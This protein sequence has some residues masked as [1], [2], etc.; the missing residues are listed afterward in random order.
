MR[1]IHT[2][3]LGVAAVLALAAGVTVAVNEDGSAQPTA[4]V[5][6]GKDA[7]SPPSAP[8]STGK[9]AC[10]HKDTPGKGWVLAI[11]VHQPGKDTYRTSAG[12]IRQAMWETDQTYDA[13][14]RRFGVSRRIRFVQDAACRPLVADLAFV[15]GRNRAEMGAEFG[16]Q[17]V[18]QPALVQK[19]WKA[20]RVKP[21]F[22][23][24]D[25]EITGSCTGGGADA[26]ISNGGVILPLWC[27][28]EAGLTHEFGHTFGLSHCGNGTLK[29]IGNDPMCRNWGTL[30]ECTSD[31]G[32]NYFLDSCRTDA[33]RYFEPKPLTGKPALPR[34]N[35][36]AFSP[37]LITNQ[38]SKPVNFRMRVDKTAECVD[39]EQ[40]AVVLRSCRA[41]P[42]Q[43]WQRRIDREGYTTLR[44]LGSGRCLQMTTT[45]KAQTA[46][47]VTARCAAGKRS[48][49]WL[50]DNGV[51]FVN[52]TGGLGYAKLDTLAGGKGDG[53]LIVRGGGAP[54]VL[55]TAVAKGSHAK[56][57]P[58]KVAIHSAAERACL[59]P[60]GTA[61]KLGSCSARWQILPDARLGGYGLRINGRCLTL[62]AI[63]D[64]D[65]R[66]V[67][68]APCNAGNR[69]QLWV[70]GIRTDG[71]TRVMNPRTQFILWADMTTVYGAGDYPDNHRFFNIY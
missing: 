21:L 16:K 55:D 28:G 6:R 25:N 14:A 32:S 70:F 1:P 50:P 58:G 8:V 17:I 65:R 27:W 4:A 22:F 29:P 68:L 43:T 5:A 36:V 11:Y 52:R 42:Q 56:P 13:S 19:L 24:G 33:F 39:G 12:M 34:N 57:V 35:N 67:A 63:G 54:F 10:D 46:P 51:G 62:G 41:V 7:G 30:P 53:T 64:R 59:G 26:G 38:P 3:L 2:I 23:V 71:T 15:K 61:V 66:A 69:D 60:K 40:A 48:Q 20:N 31:V 47:V 9:F 37:Y 45:P 44:D 18:G 49:Q